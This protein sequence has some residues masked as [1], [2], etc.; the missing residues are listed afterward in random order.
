M[1][2]KMEHG[3]WLEKLEIIEN[4]LKESVEQEATGVTIRMGTITCPCGWERSIFRM[5]KCLY[6][7]IW[8]C[9]SC[10]ESHFGKTIKQHRLDKTKR[11]NG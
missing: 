8:F 5:Y 6:C 9:V 3:G 2:N 7:D 4:Q 10:A 1:E 11:Q